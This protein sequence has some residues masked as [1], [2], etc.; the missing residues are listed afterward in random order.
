MGL[1]GTLGWEMR[2]PGPCS[3]LQFSVDCSSIQNLPTLIFII[4]GV[5]FPLPPYFYILNVSPGGR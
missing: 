4:N 2:Q 1:A 5:Q 3:T